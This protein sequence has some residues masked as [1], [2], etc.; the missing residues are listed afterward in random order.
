MKQAILTG[1]S[2]PPLGPYSQAIRAGDLLFISGQTSRGPDGE[3]IPGDIRKQTAQVLSNISAV[4]EA[5]GGGL[6]HVVKTTVYLVNMR[7]YVDMNEVYS[8]FFDDEPPAR[9][10]VQV[11]ALSSSELKVEIE[12]TAYIP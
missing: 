12:A 4:C 1:R 7:D 3:I 8:D 9:S 5:A 11:A 6:G 2:Q 10:T